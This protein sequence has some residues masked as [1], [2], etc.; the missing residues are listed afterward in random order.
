MKLHDKYRSCI[1]VYFENVNCNGKNYVTNIKINLPFRIGHLFSWENEESL[2]YHVIVGMQAPTIVVISSCDYFKVIETSVRPKTK[3]QR[4][5]V[6]EANLNFSGVN[7][8]FDRFLYP[9]TPIF[10][11]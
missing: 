7:D 4:K 2:L 3:S 6:S 11:V 1:L 9:Q 8:F 5:M 10:K